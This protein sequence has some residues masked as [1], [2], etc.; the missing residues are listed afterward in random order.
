VLATL[1]EGCRAGTRGQLA[2]IWRLAARVGRAREQKLR[3]HGN[4]RGRARTAGGKR[5][6]LSAG[7]AETGG[8]ERGVSCAAAAWRR[9]AGG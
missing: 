1:S 2:Q 7:A 5:G 6:W 8:F 3:G 4:W 9:R